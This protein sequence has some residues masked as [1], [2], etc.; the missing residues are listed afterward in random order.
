M[1]PIFPKSF[2]GFFLSVFDLATAG[3]YG[4]NEKEAKTLPG[5]QVIPASLSIQGMT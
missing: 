1:F 4:V 3:A 2:C 5:T